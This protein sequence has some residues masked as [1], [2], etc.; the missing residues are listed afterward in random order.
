MKYE[1]IEQIIR[2]I[3]EF[4]ANFLKVFKKVED[5]MTMKKEIEE[6]ILIVFVGGLAA[7]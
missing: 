5:I 3:D 2:P 7:N 6:P 1:V 4:C